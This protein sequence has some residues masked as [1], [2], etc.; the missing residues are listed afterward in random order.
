M[1][2]SVQQKINWKKAYLENPDKFRDRNRRYYMNGG[3][4]RS[5]QVYLKNKQEKKERVAKYLQN[6]KLKLF[7]ILGGLKCVYCERDKNL[8]F[9]HINSD[10]QIDRQ[11]FGGVHG[12][13]FLLYYLNHPEEAKKNLQCACFDCNLEKGSLTDEEYRAA[14]EVRKRNLLK[15]T[16]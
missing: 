4:E 3:K 13:R 7:D 16:S 11:R 10:G 2:W 15:T 14:L 9:E 12:T 8:V 6:L 1:T 5:R